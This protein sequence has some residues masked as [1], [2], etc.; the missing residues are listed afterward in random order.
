MSDLQTRIDGV[1]A[2][3]DAAAQELEAANAAAQAARARLARLSSVVI[4]PSPLA[5]AEAQATL[6]EA[7]RAVAAARA[8]LAELD[9][10][11]VALERERELAELLG[12]L[13]GTD[14]PLA[15]LPVRLE[16]RFVVRDDVHE[17]LVR[18]YPDDVHVDTHEPELTSDEVVWGRAF[19]EETWE[20]GRG[21]SDEADAR[22]RQ[23]WAQ[24]AQRFGPERAAWVA[25]TLR[26]L[27][28]DEQTDAP[29]EAEAPP[30]PSFPEPARR[31]D[32]WTRPPLVRALPSRWVVSGH[33]G[34]R[35]VLLAWGEP[36]RGSLA[37]GPDPAAPP[38][39]GGDDVLAVD[40]S[41]R[42]LVDFDA[43]VQT[44]MAL[45]IPLSDEEA[46]LGFDTL[47]AVGVST[48]PG[49]DRVLEELLQAQLYTAGL[50]FVAP[51]T[52][53]NNT[54]EVD[55]GF[56]PR[57]PARVGT[58][59]PLV[60]RTPREGTDGAVAAR[61][62]GLGGEFVARLEH[63]GRSDE[64]D[65]RAMMT[66]LWP[67]TG[68]YFL[69]Q[70]LAETFAPAAIDAARRHAI[71]FTRGRGPLPAIRVGAQ[72]YGLLPVSSLD[73]WVAREGEDQFVAGLRGLRGIWRSVIDRVPRVDRTATDD[74]PEQRILDVLASDGGS[75]AWSAR[76]LFDQLMFS[77]P[78][79]HRNAPPFAPLEQ[80]RAAL[81][82]LLAG[83]GVDWRPRLVDTVPAERP[84]PLALGVSEAG[85]TA[86]SDVIRWLRESRYETI[87]D[88]T[89]LPGERP[90]SLLYLLL[91][92]AVLTA[93]AMTA[94][95]VQL[96]VGAA[97]P[98]DLREPA[99]VDLMAAPT[100][101]TGRH[102]DRGLPGLGGRALHTL[103]AADHP[104]AAALDDLRES[105]AHLETLPAET[106]ERLLSE[107][108]DVFAYRL[109]AWITSLATRRL[110][111]MRAVKPRGIGVGGFGWLERVRPGSGRQPVEPPPGERAPVFVEPRSA[112]FVHA[113]SLNQAA[114][115]AILRSGHLSLR[116]GSGGLFDVDLSSRRVR[117]AE[118]L[119]DGIR[120]GQSL[121]AL[122]GYRF[123]RGLHDRQL[124]RYIA[125]FRR[126]APF[127][128]LLRAQVA[129]EDAER[130]AARLRG[131][132]H[133]ELAGAQASANAARARETQLRNE[134]TALPGRLAAAERD[135]ARLDEELRA[136]TADI[137]R[138]ANLI[139][140]FQTSRPPRVTD[141]LDEQLIDLQ[142]RRTSVL[143]SRNDAAT[144]VQQLRARSQ[145]IA[146]EVA[147]ASRDR[148]AAERRVSDLR[149]LPHPAF[150]AAEQA[151]AEA[152]ERHRRLLDAYRRERLFPDDASQEALLSVAAV[153]VVDGLA[154]LRQHE[155][156]QLAFGTNGLPAE[157]SPDHPALLSMLAT[158]AD[159]VDA[160]RDALVAESV[161]QLVQGRAD[162]AAA[163][164]DSVAGGD[165]PPPELEVVR[166]PR[167]GAMITH[168]VL[169]LFDA[170]EDTPLWPGA[171][172]SPRGRA[173]PALN[174]WA[175]QLLGDPARVIVRVSYVDP[176]TGQVLDASHVRLSDLGLAPIDLLY[177]TQA[178]R[179]GRH[180]DLEQLLAY[181]V[182]RDRPPGVAADA[183]V[184]IETE[185][186]PHSTAGEV[187]LA[188]VL[189]LAEA[190]G[191]LMVEARPLTN[192]DLVPPDRAA[193]VSVE[194]AELRAR[195]D[196]AEA[197]LREAA[198]ALRDAIA[199]GA[200]SAALDDRL[201]R[202]ALFGVRQAV[203]SRG[204]ET[205]G[206]SIERARQVD[207]LVSARLD[208]LQTAAAA[209]D[210]ETASVAVQQDHE[211]AR[212]QA[213][214]GAEFR[215]L[216]D[217]RPA[218]AEELG[219]G[220]AAS[221]DLQGGDPFAAAT[222]MTRT[223]RVRS[224]VDRLNTVVTYAEALGGGPPPFHVAQ[225]P[226]ADGERWVALAA[227]D[228][229]R[230]RDGA[231]SL[232]VYAARPP[233]MT[234]PLAG[235]W[236]DEWVE[237]I[238]EPNVTTGVAFHF[239]EPA[240]QAPQAVLLAVPPD[241]RPTWAFETV[242]AIALETLDLARLRAVGP[243]TLDQ[244]TNVMQALPA[245]WFSLNLQNA[246]V[247][248]D[249]RRASPHAE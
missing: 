79:L 174:A 145:T 249:F 198:A 201:A 236:I 216:P 200:G 203:P 229:A 68:G 34:G 138:I 52:P 26:P 60:P 104:A 227:G 43:A 86:I 157:G 36:V 128:D 185:R 84:F 28:L 205:S 177:L 173:E 221:L 235:L 55:A 141:H 135:L 15:L 73:R 72:P 48:L 243:E 226:F 39:A 213:V 129:A 18:I 196:A 25:W 197:Q 231:L 211:I 126:L 219:R 76:L 113:P 83:M 142:A 122:L 11:L 222:W 107:T 102:P 120:Q 163:D 207:R 97:Q 70:M 199:A 87:R 147:V 180:P 29:A 32:S 38:P 101:T 51:D 225:V 13:P 245:L 42:W 239:D 183:I 149:V 130:E 91:R 125:V 144:R 246:T 237:V 209:F 146:G 35:R 214:F 234:K 21:T 187:G 54:A 159:D 247:S 93:Y 168:R 88:E 17:I 127:G 2:E 244:H 136:I 49:G 75:F 240:A 105:L 160:V 194:V 46:P 182:D 56:S 108:L 208:A 148:Q 45:R 33:R 117:T 59:P 204:R 20:A 80:R 78:E 153:H 9:R 217:L 6:A 133:P 154:L 67:A 223:A 220:F 155:S 66:A 65:A 186:Q 62:L 40:D 3:R 81:R 95:R 82:E 61:R 27:N 210:R 123:E 242:E 96:A 110:D 8:R 69:E 4:R 131:A 10:Q 179:A 16:T 74:V 230:P 103:T 212:L 53:T 218:S 232:V 1:R 162:R 30:S 206:R 175:A 94:F 31:E 90:G 116:E 188:E 118:W 171:N 202:F 63:A 140:R 37:A 181:L 7:T 5:L 152:G 50:S 77:L 191:R 161:F 192:A 170:S 137:T 165:M 151:A 224:A 41:M 172:A 176:A 19:W 190:A 178:G 139:V 24:L 44:G 164:L 241:D 57:D 132:P 166:T 89:D 158:L 111:R 233:D 119:L 115:A 215:V 195:A 92:H 99:V 98:A 23:A 184:R 156:G 64:R 228:G 100:R 58:P 22:R 114:A 167:R 14:V 143:R 47:V 106:L 150:A 121:G 71:E 189:D 124:D 112:G 238:P 85:S 169:A 109:D 193:S 134:Q 12:D 248:T